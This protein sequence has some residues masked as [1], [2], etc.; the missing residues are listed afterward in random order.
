MFHNG[1]TQ[2]ERLRAMLSQL[3]ESPGVMRLMC[4][5]PG[6][7]SVP[8]AFSEAYPDYSQYCG[9][10]LKEAQSLQPFGG[11]TIAVLANR[12]VQV[13]ALCHPASYFSTEIHRQQG[14]LLRGAIDRSLLLNPS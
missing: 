8:A 11:H 3:P 14:I 10:S 5:I 6:H 2:F 4:E 9:N 12:S 7:P 13:V 1:S